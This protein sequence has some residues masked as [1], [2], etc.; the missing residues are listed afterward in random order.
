MVPVRYLVRINFQKSKNHITATEEVE[1]LEKEF[2]DHN[3]VQARIAA[4]SFFDNYIDSLIESM[5]ESYNSFNDIKQL[6]YPLYHP[7]TKS[8]GFP[9]WVHKILGV[10][11][12]FSQPINEDEVGE[13]RMIY[14][15]GGNDEPLDIL[16][17]LQKELEYY[18]HF[19]FD[20]GHL[21]T[22]VNFY[23]VEDDDTQNYAILKTSFDWD[24][25]DV[26]PDNLSKEDQQ[27]D[28]IEKLI[29]IGENIK[30]EFKSSL[31]YDFID[32]KFS[33]NVIEKN[34]KT[35]CAFLNSKSGGF[36]FIGVRD[37]RKIQG[38]AHDFRLSNKPGNDLD[39][40]RLQF[41]ALLTRHFEH[42]I[43]NLL[44]CGFVEIDEKLIYV[45]KVSPSNTPSFL[46]QYKRDDVTGKYDK[47]EYAFYYRS[48]ANSI[49]IQ[50]KKDLVN[51]CLERFSK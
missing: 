23:D 40:F 13:E 25:L 15:F 27:S 4:L 14:G 35:I 3:P 10:F 21:E 7:D 44:E 48:E 34:A 43:R 33:F 12:V 5:G 30:V 20:K 46:K 16:M 51:Y 26:P 42:R 2:V 38:L 6:L 49:E 47:V 11:V 18:D 1:F 50:D 8:Y 24:G 28:I 31:L 45:V 41:S 17:A 37:D 19:N 29:Y 22:S 32:N 9:D 36:L 39:Y